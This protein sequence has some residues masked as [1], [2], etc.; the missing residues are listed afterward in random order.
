[1]QSAGWFAGSIPLALLLSVGVCFGLMWLLVKS[2]ANVK[3]FLVFAV[4]I[5]IY[6]GGK[7]RLSGSVPGAVLH[8]PRPHHRSALLQNSGVAAHGIVR[9]RRIVLRNSRDHHNYDDRLFAVSRPAGRTGGTP[10]LRCFQPNNIRTAAEKPLGPIPSIFCRPGNSRLVQ[11]PS[12]FC[13]RKGIS[14]AASIGASFGLSPMA[15]KSG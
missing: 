10:C 2:R 8:P 12:C 14:T 5:V 3:F 11:V 15:A 13:T 1:M 7:V 4:L 9:G 6:V